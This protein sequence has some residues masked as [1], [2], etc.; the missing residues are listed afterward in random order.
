MGARRPQ[1]SERSEESNSQAIVKVNEKSDTGVA[2]IT[3]QKGNISEGK[4]ING[5]TLVT[6]EKVEGSEGLPVGGAR[7]GRTDEHAEPRISLPM[8]RI[9]ESAGPA[10]LKLIDLKQTLG[11][12]Q[13]S[14]MAN[15][16][17]QRQQSN[18]EMWEAMRAQ[19]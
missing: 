13:Q 17:R 3:I 15:I 2:D 6:T 16:D 10:V 11:D 14:M 7:S 18:W 19:F 1:S 12:W 5:P 8:R 9:P 4:N